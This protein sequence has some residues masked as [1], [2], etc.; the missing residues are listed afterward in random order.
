MSRSRIVATRSLLLPLVLPLL[1]GLLTALLSALARAEPPAMKEHKSHPRLEVVSRDGRHSVAIGGFFQARYAAAFA[2]ES[3]DASRFGIPRT[4]LYV[5]GRLFSRDIRYRLMLG[6]APYELD[7]KLY[8][9]YVEWWAR[10]WARV[11]GGYFKI[12]VLREWVESARLLASVDRSASAQLLSPGRHPGV[13]L[14]GGLAGDAVEY[15]L[16]AFGGAGQPTPDPGLL[17]VVAGRVV[18]NTTRRTIEGEVDLRRSPL[19]LSI[20]ASG[21]AAFG[22]RTAGRRAHEL[23]GA[24]ELALRVRGLDAAVEVAF[25]ERDDGSV[26]ER[27]AASYARANY[28][29]FAAHT[30]FGVRASQ[31]L[32]LDAGERTRTDLD[33]DVTTLLDGHDLKLQLSGG[34]AY[35]PAHHLW[36]GLVQV[37]VQAAF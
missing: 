28:H 19:A 18:W 11:R 21:Y 4:R 10:P 27:V 20:G 24:V 36:E 32:D 1:M 17:P 15:W 9:A 13:M 5:F 12:P 33:L 8:D 16:G 31:I 25:R 35:L 29:V 22:A 7:V 3:L 6:T 30:A 2:A 14:S 23:L 37:Q 26:R 34:P